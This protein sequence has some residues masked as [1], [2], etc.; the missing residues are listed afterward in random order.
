MQHYVRKEARRLGYRPK[1]LL[2]LLQTT[3]LA[4]VHK[5]AHGVFVCVY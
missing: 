3:N 5:H 1:L 2:W 4:V